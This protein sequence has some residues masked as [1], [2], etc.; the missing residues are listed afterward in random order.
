MA[1]PKK[2][3]KP[4]RPTSGPSIEDQIRLGPEIA[5][6]KARTPRQQWR[7]IVRGAHARGL[8]VAGAVTPGIPDSMRE[9]TKKSLTE[10]ARKTVADQ[11]KPVEVELDQRET[12]VKALDAKRASDE[13][14]YRRWLASGHD[15]LRAQARSADT[16]LLQ[17]ERDTA[18]QLQ[19]GLAQTQAQAHANAA[20]NAGVISNTQQST[21]LDISDVAQR[22]TGKLAA[23]RQRSRDL[24]GTG[25]KQAAVATAA[26]FAAAAAADGKRQS[27]IWEELGKVSDAR[28]KLKAE[29]GSETAKEIARLIDQETDKASRNREFAAAADKLGLDTE[30]FTAQQKNEDRKYK[31][32]LRKYR[33]DKWIA[34]NKDEVARTKI[35]LDYDKIAAANGRAAADRALRKE[36]DRRRAASGDDRAANST[37]I[38]RSEEQ[39]ETVNT[40]LGELRR[41]HGK[42]TN[43]H[44]FRQRLREKG[45]SDPVIDIAED[46]RRNG[47]KL[48]AR[49]R[50]KA[51]AI[52]IRNPERLWD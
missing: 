6:L 29:F 12:R 20:G 11:F 49:G 25:D 18:Q 9:R 23:Q 35:D 1:A 43:I 45:W 50:A 27:E 41:L 40:A 38:R 26:A 34:E 51:R 33:L 7:R 44:T 4:K 10:Q 28:G 3:K 46:L 16:M 42:S 47:G 21:A 2:P 8:T 17:H 32:E 19:A 24:V 30:K 22:E 15:K 31:T 52:G 5:A 13:D 39:Y 14:H 37:Q 48:S 36:L